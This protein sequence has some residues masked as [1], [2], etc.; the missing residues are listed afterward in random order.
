M[1]FYSFFFA[2][3]S[4]H[5]FLALGEQRERELVEMRGAVLLA[6]VEDLL[7]DHS[8]FGGVLYAHLQQTAHRGPVAEQP[9]EGLPSELRRIEIV[10][11]HVLLRRS[12]SGRLLLRAHLAD[13]AD[14][15]VLLAELAAHGPS[16]EQQKVLSTKI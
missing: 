15:V 14:E 11:G 13:A 7:D 1:Y 8:V 5:R 3:Q 16:E 12:A 2:S 9:V 10:L 6:E 4:T